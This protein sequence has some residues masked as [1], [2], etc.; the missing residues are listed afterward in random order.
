MKHLPACRILIHPTA[1][2]S[3]A[4]IEA[5]QQRT[6]CIAVITGRTGQLVRRP[7]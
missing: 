4:A 3:P 5:L 6:G 7:A 1:A 2:T